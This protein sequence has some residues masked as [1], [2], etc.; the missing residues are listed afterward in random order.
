MDRTETKIKGPEDLIGKR[1]CLRGTQRT[2]TA[3]RVLASNSAEV[4][5][6]P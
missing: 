5:V 4:E 3:T 2:G 1:V 6:R